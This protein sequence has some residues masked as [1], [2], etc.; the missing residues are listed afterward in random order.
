[1]SQM[2]NILQVREEYRLQQWRQIVQ[3]CRESGLS[4]RDF[5][6]QNGITEKTYYYWLRKL[7]MAA[8]DKDSPRIVELERKDSGEDMIHIRFRNAEMT[9]PAGTDADAITAILRSLQKL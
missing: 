7:R 6:R 1:M 5:C 2:E 8:A 4:N 3:Q 9:L